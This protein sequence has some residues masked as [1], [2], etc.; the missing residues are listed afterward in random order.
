VITLVLNQRMGECVRR[1][2]EFW[3][4]WHVRLCIFQH[5]YAFTWP[6]KTRTKNDETFTDVN[7][8]THDRP[9]GR[10][11]GN[12]KHRGSRRLFLG[13]VREPIDS[14]SHSCA[15]DTCH[16]CN[17]RYNDSNDRP[18]HY[19]SSDDHHAC[20]QASCATPDRA[21]DNVG[22]PRFADYDSHHNTGT[23]Y[24]CS[25]AGAWESLSEHGAES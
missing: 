16:N 23:T 2:Q 17:R 6:F 24:I 8:Q 25:T 5:S 13:T 9:M 18:L 14:A 20:A 15:Y 12:C 21:A 19:P 3:H 22:T 1:S 11:L 4:E 10:S 7:K